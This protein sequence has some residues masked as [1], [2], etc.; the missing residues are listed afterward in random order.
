MTK[1]RRKETPR[2]TMW[3]LIGDNPNLSVPW[4]LMA[5]YAYYELDEPF[6]P[7]ADFDALA[8]FML[9]D[10]EN[11]QHRHKHLITED[12]LRAGTLLRR[13]FPEIVKGAA[14]D[15]IQRSKV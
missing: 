8:S 9:E 1:K 3:R 15:I 4:Y 5:S 14:L 6:L 11:I 10:W 2:D 13:D 12:D 7:D